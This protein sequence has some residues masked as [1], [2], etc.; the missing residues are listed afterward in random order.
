[1]SMRRGKEGAEASSAT[2]LAIE[3]AAYLPG[4][5]WSTNLGEGFTSC[6]PMR[7]CNCLPRSRRT[8]LPTAL[9]VNVRVPTECL[10]Y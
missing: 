3:I 2:G 6:R 7:Y 4:S 9:P 10:R 1:M 5:S 8:R